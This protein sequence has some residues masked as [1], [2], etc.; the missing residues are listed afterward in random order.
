[1]GSGNIVNQDPKFVKYDGGVFEY[2]DDFNLQ[3]GSPAIGAGIGG[4][5]LGIY[6]GSYPF[7]IDVGKIVPEVTSLSITNTSVPQGGELEFK[8]TAVKQ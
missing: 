5:D 2:T 3:T 4:V 7:S 8:F 1:M 6:G